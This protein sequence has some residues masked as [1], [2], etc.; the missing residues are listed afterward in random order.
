MP[1]KNQSRSDRHDRAHDWDDDRDDDD[2]RRYQKNGYYGSGK[3]HKKESKMSRFMD[4]F[5]F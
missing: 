3:Y 5:D 1:I 2:H 4:L